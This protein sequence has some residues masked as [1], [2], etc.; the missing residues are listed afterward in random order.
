MAQQSRSVVSR[1]VDRPHARLTLPG[2]VIFKQKRLAGVQL[3]KIQD[4]IVVNGVPEILKE[5]VTVAM[6]IRV[7]PG[8]KESR[9]GRLSKNTTISS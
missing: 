8:K 5:D 3:L 7:D 4:A 1:V 6:G 2:V 9:P